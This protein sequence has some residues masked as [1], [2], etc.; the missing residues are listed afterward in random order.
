MSTTH[1]TPSTP[2][3]RREVL[4]PDETFEAELRRI[5]RI[6]LFLGL[7]VASV[8]GCLIGWQGG[9]LIQALNRHNQLSL[10][11][12]TGLIEWLV[13]KT[14][15]DQSE[16]E[17]RLTEL[18]ETEQTQIQHLWEVANA[19][20]WGPDPRPLRRTGGTVPSIPEKLTSSIVNTI[21]KN[22]QGA[23]RALC[24]MVQDYQEISQGQVL[25]SRE[26]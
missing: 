8:L 18:S 15:L 2:R 6:S 21:A 17:A 5:R 9:E 24:H 1:L 11:K 10:F 22:Q 25:K 7:P 14:N 16:I 3:L 12:G 4:L 19:P 20:G 26:L 13:T 23:D